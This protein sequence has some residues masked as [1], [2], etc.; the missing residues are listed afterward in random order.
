VN[1]SDNEIVNNQISGNGADT[2]DPASPGATGISIL[3][4]ASVPGVVIAQNTF[5][6]EIVDIT[7][8]APSGTVEAHMNSFSGIEIGIDAESTGAF[9]ATQNWWG[10]P[11]GPG[12]VGCSTVSGS[13]VYAP[14]WLAAPLPA[15]S[16]ALP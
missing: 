10:C 16:P 14:S 13:S 5:S 8:S 3:S 15:S 9:D 1:L 11:S 12:G 4:F 7:F 2:D 6:S